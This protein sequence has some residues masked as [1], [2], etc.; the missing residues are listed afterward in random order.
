MRVNWLFQKHIFDEN[1]DSLVAE[2]ERQ[3]FR[4][5]VCEFNFA[6]KNDV[7]LELFQPEECVVFYGSLQLCRKIQRF[8]KWIPGAYCNV[9]QFNCSYYYPKFGNLLLNSDYIMLPFGDL[10]RQQLFLTERLDGSIFIRPNSGQK[11]FTGD[12]IRRETWDQDLKHFEL[13]GANPDTIIVAA[14]AQKVAAEWR[15][16]VVDGEIVSGSQY[17]VD[18]DREPVAYVPNNVWEFGQQAVNNSNFE[19][20]PAWCIDICQREDGKIF[21]LEANSFSGAGIYASPQEAI[22]RE[23][24]KVAWKEWCI[25]NHEES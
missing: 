3:G 10:Q 5:K 9:E 12:I 6:S 8:A 23:V 11:I 18:S 17:F 7:F 22:I 13:C 4:S 21:V 2:V 16:V 19:P 1:L 15:L 20:D 24:S 14:K 25:Y